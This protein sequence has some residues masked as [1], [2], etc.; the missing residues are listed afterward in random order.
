MCRLHR[1]P[2]RFWPRND[3]CQGLSVYVRL[4]HLHLPIDKTGETLFAGTDRLV[5]NRRR[6]IAIRYRGSGV[7]PTSRPRYSLAIRFYIR[8]GGLFEVSGSRIVRQ[9][10]EV[11]KPSGIL[12]SPDC[13]SNRY[14]PSFLDQPGARDLGRT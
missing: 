8:T 11:A 2:V 7:D 13:A 12:G 9:T 5:S 10:L 6:G 4:P 1:I 14:L 3:E